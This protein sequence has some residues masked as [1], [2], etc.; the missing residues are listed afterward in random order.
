[1]VSRWLAE[2]SE[3]IFGRGK[4]VARKLGFLET[5]AGGGVV[6]SFVPEFGRSNLEFFFFF[7]KLSITVEYVEIFLFFF[8][9]VEAY[10]LGWKDLEM[11]KRLVF[12]FGIFRNCRVDD[13]FFRSS[14]KIFL[15][16][17]GVF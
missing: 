16:R 12:L 7:G 6:L 9:L 1:M 8:Y 5:L 11:W 3:G 15:H 4:E 13:R 14:F 10:Y 17:D 2:N